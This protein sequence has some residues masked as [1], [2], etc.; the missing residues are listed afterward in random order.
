MTL[1]ERIEGLFET[2]VAE[3]SASRE[4]QA[5]ESGSAT[6]TVTGGRLAG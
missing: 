4:F 3:L 5:L 1:R 2:Q 6:E